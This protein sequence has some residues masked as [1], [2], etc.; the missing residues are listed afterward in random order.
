MDGW[1]GCRPS[2]DDAGVVYIGEYG[3]TWSGRW[4]GFQL[5]LLQFRKTESFALLLRLQSSLCILDAM[6]QS[7]YMQKNSPFALFVR[8]ASN[9]SGF[10]NFLYQILLFANS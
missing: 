1:I 4:R 8:G 3:R 5:N 10:T 9:S 7:L 2:E 6:Q